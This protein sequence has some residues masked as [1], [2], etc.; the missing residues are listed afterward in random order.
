ML[1]GRV[2]SDRWEKVDERLIRVNPSNRVLFGILLS[3]GN[4]NLLSHDV[5]NIQY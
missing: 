1:A 4:I 2:D 3:M 5:P